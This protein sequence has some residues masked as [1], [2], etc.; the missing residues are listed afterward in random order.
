M[1]RRPLIAAAVIALG[2]SMLVLTGL[3]SAQSLSPDKVKA[4]L[5]KKLEQRGLD[6]ENISR[7]SPANRPS[8]RVWVCNWYAK[9][10]GQGGVPYECRG[11]AVFSPRTDRWRIDSCRSSIDPQ[12]PLRPRPGP[13]P[14]FGYSGTEFYN[15]SQHWYGLLQRSGATVVRQGLA[16]SAVEPRPG[17]FNWTAFDAV[18]QKMLQ[19]GIRPLWILTLAPCW[20]QP[21]GA[22]CQSGGFGV[23]HPSGGHYA[24]FANFA[25]EAAKRY[26]ESA[27]IEVWNE[28]NFD[29]FWG[30]EADVNGYIRMFK[31]TARAIHGANPQMPVYTSGLSPHS[32]RT[33]AA[34]PYQVFLKK[35]YRKGAAQ[36]ADGISAHPFPSIRYTSHPKSGGYIERI[37][38]HMARIDGVMRRFKD[39]KTPIA[40]TEV[41]VKTA[42]PEAYSP[43]QQA[44]ALVD[45]YGLF[46]RI[47]GVPMVLIH[48]FAE[49]P[50]VSW[51]VIS[52]Q[53]KPKRAYCRLAKLRGSSC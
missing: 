16:W 17:E 44:K 7:C 42:G 53:G 14:E 37:R 49:T 47:R 30:G 27:G 32:K 4:L 48:S 38:V 35:M 21:D 43:K 29:R 10:R 36:L 13:H 31:L 18:Y 41:G 12:I 33:P 3:G 24:D 26:P 23:L 2:L 19:R 5:E 25:A 45:I 52:A 11:N 51:G 6:V 50:G 28:A 46:R 20:A 15:L 1:K 8:G 40:V 34:I 39:G 9:G 22:D